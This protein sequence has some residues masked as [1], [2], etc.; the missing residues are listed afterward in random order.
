MA[1]VRYSQFAAILFD[2]EWIRPYTRP[3][4]VDRIRWHLPA[5]NPL[6]L[7]PFWHHGF[8][9]GTLGGRAPAGAVVG[10]KGFLVSAIPLA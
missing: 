5:L 4:H 2:G 10:V 6:A 3:A 8:F 1:E 7:N 9:V